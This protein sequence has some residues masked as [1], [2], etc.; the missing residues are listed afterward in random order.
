[1]GPRGT[2]EYL[3]RMRDRYVRAKTRPEKGQLLTEAMAVTGYHRK[4]LIR[5]WR[6][7]EPVDGRRRRRRGRARRYGPSAVWHDD[8]V[9]SAHHPAHH[10]S[11]RAWR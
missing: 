1:M 9:V 6:R 2:S 10:A 8:G 4:A 5:V 7:P 11:P 3:A